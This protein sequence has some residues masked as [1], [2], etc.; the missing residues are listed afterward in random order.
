MRLG[1]FGGLEKDGGL[2]GLW[3]CLGELERD[4]CFVCSFI[5]LEYFLLGGCFK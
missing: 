4:V 3:A 2:V 1:L 5:V